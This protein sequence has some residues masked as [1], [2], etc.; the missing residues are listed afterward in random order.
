MCNIKVTIK[1]G[2]ASVFT[3]FNRDFVAAIRNVGGRKWD[4]ESKCWT[5]PEESLPQVRQIMMDVYGE[6]DLPDAGGSVTVK[7]TFTVT[8]P[9]VS[10]RSVSP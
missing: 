2:R 7:V 10:G 6:T 9:Q 1:D 3:P 4:G 8:L 5:V